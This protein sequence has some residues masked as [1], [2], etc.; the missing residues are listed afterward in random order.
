MRKYNG[1][2]QPTLENQGCFFEKVTFA[3]SG[4]SQSERHSGYEIVTFALS[5]NNQRVR[6]ILGSKNKLHKTPQ[7][8]GEKSD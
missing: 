6:G 5:G 4:N 3:Q 1:E 2:S 7:A 8:G